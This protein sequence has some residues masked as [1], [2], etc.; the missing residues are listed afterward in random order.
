M[1]SKSGRMTG[2]ILFN[3]PVQQYETWYEFKKDL[4]S[5]CGHPILNK[6]WLRIKPQIALPW[7]KSNMRSA[8]LKLKK[9]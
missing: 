2:V 6:I 3:V 9:I 5:F 4:E 1:D 8:L 7:D